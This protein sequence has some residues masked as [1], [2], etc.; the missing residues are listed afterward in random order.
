MKTYFKLYMR[1][2]INPLNAKDPIT[3]TENEFISLSKINSKK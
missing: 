2:G 1:R 3:A